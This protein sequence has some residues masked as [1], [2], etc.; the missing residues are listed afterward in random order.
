MPL[1]S[2]TQKIMAVSPRIHHITSGPAHQ[3]G[4]GFKAYFSPYRRNLAENSAPSLRS[5]RRERC[6]SM[7][8]PALE[9]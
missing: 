2:S 7:P 5:S 6:R 4:I 1:S 3:W 9:R 8:P